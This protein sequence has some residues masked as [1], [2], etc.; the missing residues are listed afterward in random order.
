[1]RYLFNFLSKGWTSVTTPLKP[2][3]PPISP[4][5]LQPPCLVFFLQT[6]HKAHLSIGH[7]ALSGLMKCLSLNKADNTFEG[8]QNNRH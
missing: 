8:V 7:G 2:T 3:L 6:P 4:L 1:M 5:S